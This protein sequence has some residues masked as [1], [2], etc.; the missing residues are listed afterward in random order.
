MVTMPVGCGGQPARAGGRESGRD[1]LLGLAALMLLG[2]ASVAA[3]QSSRSN[4]ADD[5][6]PVYATPADVAD[7][8]RVADGMCA[9]CHGATG[10][11]A[12]RG[13]PHLAGQRPSYLY[14]KIKAYQTGARDDHAMESA[15]KFLNDDALVKVAA[16]YASLEPSP[17]LAAD[18]AKKGAAPLDPLAAGKAAA[19]ACA[20]CHGDAG[21]S[22]TPGTPSLIGFDEK[23]FAAA[24]NAYRGGRRKHELMQSIAASTSDADVRH[25]ALHYALQKAAPAQTPAKGNA[26]A[27]KAAAAACA[28]CHGEQGV[29]TNPA[30]PSLAGQDADYF[31]AA[32]R[33]Y[34]DGTRTEQTMKLAAAN[35]SDAVIA[36]LAA[37]YAG[38]QPR[39]PKVVKPLT[40]EQWVQRCDRCHGVNG[41]STDPRA[42]ALAAQRI[43][44]L[45]K[46]MQAYQG[47]QR[48]SSA[49]AA[50]SG[51]LTDADV[52][53]LAAHYARQ[54][55]RPF[56]FVMV[57][58]K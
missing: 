47:G 22:A 46:A 29:S 56:V 30:N 45:Q 51:S 19:E 38:Q 34:K 11:S 17:P 4:T 54:K 23:Y 18:V 13:V 16:Y 14:A 31:A 39:Q 6:R 37:Y 15:I 48:R 50:M 53:G 43:E 7:G 40:L 32:M 1:L 5:L 36:D 35:V 26:A 44:Y 27:G 20:G 2:C 10:I 25:L 52:A 21:V 28:G 49:M 12:T 9:K 57:P 41:N 42:P 58:S 55:A 3:A 24:M 33:A 8:R